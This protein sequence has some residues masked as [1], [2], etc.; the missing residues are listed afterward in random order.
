MCRAVER[1]GQQAGCTYFASFPD[2]SP[3]DPTE[4]DAYVH[5]RVS[6]PVRPTGS[7]TV[8]LPNGTALLVPSRDL[9][10]LAL[11]E[12]EPPELTAFV[13]NAGNPT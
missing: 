7:V 8:Y 11:A 12:C 3:T 6:K 9:V 1:S 2:G 5:V 10:R 4:N 13:R